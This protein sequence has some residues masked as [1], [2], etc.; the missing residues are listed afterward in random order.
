MYNHT[1]MIKLSETNQESTQKVKNALAG[2]S[3]AV[4]PLRDIEVGNNVGESK[5]AWNIFVKARFDNMD[6]YHQYQKHPAHLE[7]ATAIR[8]FMAEVA[9]VDFED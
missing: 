6:G 7:V 1:I 5:N 4:P 8:P 2:L 3:G 9:I